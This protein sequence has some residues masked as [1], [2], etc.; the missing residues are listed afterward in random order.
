M[1][2]CVQDCNPFT[3]K[4]Y[5]KRYFASMIRKPDTLQTPYTTQPVCLYHGLVFICT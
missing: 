3:P 4:I 2:V 5:N 1:M